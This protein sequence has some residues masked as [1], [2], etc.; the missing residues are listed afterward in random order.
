MGVDMLIYLLT[1]LIMG[2]GFFTSSQSEEFDASYI[3]PFLLIMLTWPFF[4]GASIG[5]FAIFRDE[6]RRKERKMEGNP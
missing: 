4:V 1:G 2:I 5:K 3:W 6:V